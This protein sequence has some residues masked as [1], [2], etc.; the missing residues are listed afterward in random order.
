MTD[1]VVKAGPDGRSSPASGEHCPSTHLAGGNGSPH[2][3]QGDGIP[4]L[5]EL[6]YGSTLVSQQVM[7]AAGGGRTADVRD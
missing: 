3:K 5:Q 1:V 4:G 6:L 2:D 7:G